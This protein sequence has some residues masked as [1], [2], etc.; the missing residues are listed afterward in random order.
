MMD[1]FA[2]LH[3]KATG[4]APTI[5]AKPDSLYGSSPTQ[6]DLV[7][8]ISPQDGGYAA[9]RVRDDHADG[10]S[11]VAA[12]ALIAATAV[13]AV[14]R[15]AG[16]PDDIGEQR[17]GSNWSAEAMAEQIRAL[18]QRLDRESDKASLMT[19]GPPN[20]A[21]A[22]P[23]RVSSTADR[24]LETASP[25]Q[26][27]VNG[28]PRSAPL[29][30]QISAARNRRGTFEDE[31][32]WSVCETEQLDNQGLVAAPGS[33]ASIG[34]LAPAAHTIIARH[35][36]AE[37]LVPSSN[38]S[39]SPLSP[40]EGGPAEDAEP[41]RKDTM[42][43]DLIATAPMRLES[44]SPDNGRPSG[45]EQPRA[46][47]QLAAAITASRAERGTNQRPAQRAGISLAPLP[48][49]REP[50]LQS[51]QDPAGAAKSS[52]SRNEPTSVQVSIGR[53]EI[54]EQR[55]PPP[56]ATRRPPSPR[57]GLREYLDRRLRGARDE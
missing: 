1:Y 45:V 39:F 51:G 7:A 54:R 3:L 28:P 57:L 27:P 37:S 42:A 11:T 31:P 6:S 46:S 25:D 33:P 50:S 48:P 35:G 44:G 55:P 17:S 9:E 13:R 36:F 8:P 21:I 29:I 41:G 53:I 18:E 14:A 56:T 10:Q 30:R 22:P 2:V 5:R 12:S 19:E 40:G 20:G 4:V 34:Q 47:H 15:E 38:G 32:Q 52:A 43:N 16:S 49:A 24:I 26:E 23:L